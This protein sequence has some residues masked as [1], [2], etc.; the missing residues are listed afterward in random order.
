MNFSPEELALLKD[1]L[2]QRVSWLSKNINSLPSEKQ[3]S[4]TQLLTKLS[5]ILTKFDSQTKSTT[6]NLKAADVR[7]LVVDD[8]EYC[9]K[10]LA[11]NLEQL[12]FINVDIAMDGQEAINLMYDTPLPFHLIL[13]DWNMPIKSGLEVHS[14]MLA[15]DRYNESQFVM[16]T[17]ITQASQIREAID[18]G[19]NDYLA[20]PIEIEALRK[21]LTR[22]FPEALL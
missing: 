14:A 5:A 15:S 19:V 7:T 21:K 20:K 8:D 13:S 11:A 1:T 6:A 12:G 4:A 9:A 16:T 22:F 3:A 18:H 17:S 10:L 2:G